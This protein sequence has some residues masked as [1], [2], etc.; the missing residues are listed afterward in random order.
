MLK[1][2]HS[3]IIDHNMYMDFFTLCQI[4]HFQIL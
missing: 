1:N 3:A 4:F 2:K